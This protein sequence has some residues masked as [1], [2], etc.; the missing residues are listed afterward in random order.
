MAGRPLATIGDRSEAYALRLSPDNRRAS[1]VLGDPNND[2]W[3][4]ELDR[5]VRARLTTDAQV[6]MSPSGRGTAP[7]SSSSPSESLQKKDVDYVLATLPANGAGQRK[8][9][10]RLADPHRADRLVARR[11]LRS[12][13]TRAR[14]ARRTSGSSRSRSRTRHFRSCSRRSSTGTASSHP[15]AAGSPT[16]R[17]SR[18]GSRSTS[19]PF[20]QAARAGR[21]PPTAA[22]SPAGAPTGRPSTSFRSPDSSWP[23]PSTAR[24]AQFVVKDVKPLFSV[25]LFVGPRISCGYDVTSDGKRF[26]INSA[27]QPRRRGWCWCRTGR[28]RW[29]SREGEREVPPSPCPSPPSGGEGSFGG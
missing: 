23:R 3:I 7:R 17:S 22:R 18:E 27:G 28:W 8:E 14:S 6:I 4:Y 25:N 16:C 1:L 10:F 29:R 12:A 15:T 20:R 13:S 11:A 19:R 2:I 26:L 9:L 21:F 5:G 24:G